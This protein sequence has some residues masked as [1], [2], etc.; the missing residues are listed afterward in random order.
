MAALGV[1]AQGGHIKGDLS[2]S[3]KTRPTRPSDDW[4][5]RLRRQP[6]L[7]KRDGWALERGQVSVIVSACDGAA[8]VFGTHDLSQHRVAALR[9]SSSY[10]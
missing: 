5:H 9:H 3:L 8:R 1:V 6:D 2:P 10:C 4:F 7:T